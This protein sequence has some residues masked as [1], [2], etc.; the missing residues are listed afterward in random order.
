MLTS[1][2][3]K[4]GK[5]KY[6][7]KINKNGFTLIEILA[8]IVIMGIL[9]GVTVPSVTNYILDARKDT[10]ISTIKGYV[11]AVRNKVA[12]NDYKF[13]NKKWC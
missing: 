1:F 12:I 5:S 10:Y 2:Y 7:K 8:V 11:D 6:M 3:K 9:I 4:E 13:T